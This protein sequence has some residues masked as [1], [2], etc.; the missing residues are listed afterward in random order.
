MHSRKMHLSRHEIFYLR[1]V[2]LGSAYIRIARDIAFHDFA[3]R[4][5][6]RAILI[7]K[8]CTIYSGS[9]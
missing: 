1:T 7:A 5:L 3:G 9:Q 2:Q 6:S 8:R 4:I